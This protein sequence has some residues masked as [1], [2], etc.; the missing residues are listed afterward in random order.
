MEHFAYLFVVYDEHQFAMFA[1]GPLCHYN[2]MWRCAYSG[3]DDCHAPETSF[4]EI[5]LSRKN[6]PLFD[7]SCVVLELKKYVSAIKMVDDKLPELGSWPHTANIVITIEPVISSHLRMPAVKIVRE[8]VLEDF[9]A[10]LLVLCPSRF[11]LFNT[12]ELLA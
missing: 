10:H 4:Q 1:H 7:F 8:K 9:F 6:L 11:A 2:R 3:H 12:V 5:L